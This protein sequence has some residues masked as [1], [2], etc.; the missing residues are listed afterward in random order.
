MPRALR[1]HVFRSV[2]SIQHARQCSGHATQHIR[3]LPRISIAMQKSVH[4]IDSR[5]EV[6]TPENIAFQYR[7]A[8]PF[9]R[10]PAYL[11]D[12]LIR[13][14]AVFMASWALTLLGLASGSAVRGFGIGTLLLFWFGLEWFYGG[15]FET[16]WNGQTPGK[17]AIGVRVVA[18]DGQPINALQAVMRNIL[19]VAD[20]LPVVTIPLGPAQPL[21]LFLYQVGLWVPAFNDRYQRLGD[22][23]CGTMVVLDEASAN[24]GVARIT[25]PEAIRLAGLVPRNFVV[26]RSLART[27]SLYVDRRR[28]LSWQRRLEIAR[29]LAEPLRK[30]FNLPPQTN[31]DLLLAGVYYRAFAAPGAEPVQP[32]AS[33]L[34]AQVVV[35][36]ANPPT[37]SPEL[38]NY[39]DRIS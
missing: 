3:T 6:V 18:T 27:L 33:P 29:P 17:W 23:A 37:A 26:T 38:Q 4:Q 12:I 13:V 34:Q 2:D 14:A 15:V 31:P 28:G 11:I 35:V 16:F 9:R 1:G 10:L 25:E 30:I 8:G 24:Y 19:R 21:E 36:A 5:I 22:L 39:L 20:A 32:P 7:V